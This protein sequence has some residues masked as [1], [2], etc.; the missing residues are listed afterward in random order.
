MRNDAWSDRHINATLGL[1]S[2]TGRDGTM[3]KPVASFSLYQP[4]P[5][6][7]IVGQKA[8]CSPKC[9]QHCTYPPRSQGLC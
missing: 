6:I 1:S 9:K 7:L 2:A 5:L 4:P 3:I 8:P